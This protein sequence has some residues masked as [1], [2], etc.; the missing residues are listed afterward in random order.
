MK[1]WTVADIPAQNNILAV[2]TGTHRSASKG[3][4]LGSETLGV[5]QK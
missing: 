4:S 3:R 1:T 2:V 5:L